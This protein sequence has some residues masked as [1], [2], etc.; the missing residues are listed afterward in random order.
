MR[1]PLLLAATVVVSLLVSGCGDER[2]RQSSAAP[3]PG[4][5]ASAPAGAK[6]SPALPAVSGP[7]L[8]IGGDYPYTFQGVAGGT[9]PVAEGQPAT[10]GQ[11]FAAVFYEV[12]GKLQDRPLPAP[13]PNM[14]FRWDR[15]DGFQCR[16]YPVK[17]SRAYFP[18]S[19]TSQD[20]EA[21]P[22]DPNQMLSPGE[23]YVG[24]ITAEIPQS[25]DYRR[26]ELC[27]LT[28]VS[29]KE[30]IPVGALPPLPKF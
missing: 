4:Q 25:A 3:Q 19:L 20:T 28:F 12:K 27:T 30:C 29:I 18:R 9:G 11:V 14:V 21:Q 23:S 1:S 8:V 5:E 2:P 13:T 17:R 16:S 10:A 15:C 24:L 7:V 6:S 22:A 26:L